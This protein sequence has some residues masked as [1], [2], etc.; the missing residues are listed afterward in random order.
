MSKK[1]DIDRAARALIGI[2]ETKIDGLPDHPWI[3]GARFADGSIMFALADLKRS[4]DPPPCGYPE[5][6]R[7]AQVADRTGA[8]GDFL[9][10]LGEQGV[11]LAAYD[12]GTEHWR[13]DV[14]GTR[15]ELLG[16]W[17]GVNPTRLQMEKVEMIKRLHEMNGQA[18]A[19]KFAEVEEGHAPQP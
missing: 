4:L 6:D 2:L 1:E 5:H 9:E 16:R 10:W 8:V 19:R 15:D 13:P 12:D 18:A 7:L 14:V 11:R 17:S 3:P